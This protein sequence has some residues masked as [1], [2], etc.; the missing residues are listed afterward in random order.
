MEHLLLI[1]YIVIFGFVFCFLWQ[2]RLQVGDIVK[3]RVQ[4]IAY[5]GIFVEVYQPFDDSIKEFNMF[6]FT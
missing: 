5:F 6:N 4:K 2:A 3:C 1:E